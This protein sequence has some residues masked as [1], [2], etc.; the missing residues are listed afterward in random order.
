MHFG[1][2]RWL[3]QQRFCHCNGPVDGPV[4][5]DGAGNRRIVR[6]GPPGRDRFVVVGHFGPRG[7]KNQKADIEVKMLG[8]T[9]SGRNGVDVDVDGGG[10]D[11]KTVDPGLLG[12]LL[13]RHCGQVAV[14]IGMASRL[15]PPIELA[16]VE[17]KRLGPGGIDDEGR[18]GQVSGQATA[19]Q[20]VWFT[21]P[22]LTSMPGTE[23]Q[24]PTASL[25]GHRAFER[26]RPQL[27]LGHRQ[28]IEAGGQAR[29]VDG[30]QGVREG[31][32]KPGGREEREV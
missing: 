29:V 26:C 4:Q 23:L 6:V 22:T 13:Q 25:F 20:R 30:R 7:S 5:L 21:N 28:V 19:M 27:V 32:G 10:H 12:G 2:N 14:T 3:P 15:E 9:G 1:E 24:D 17:Q 18:A 11:D 16:M 8:F 31:R